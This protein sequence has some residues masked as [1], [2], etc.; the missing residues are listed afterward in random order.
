MCQ[1]E[2]TPPVRSSRQAI[3]HFR[4]SK[5]IASGQDDGHFKSK[6]G[7]YFTPGRFYNRPELNPVL[8]HVYP[9][10]Y[11]TWAKH[12]RRIV[13]LTPGSAIPDRVFEKGTFDQ[14]LK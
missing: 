7:A 11:S 10:C 6:S 9:A 5:F 12:G 2:A 13:N 14:W 4:A 3:G 8:T 1:M